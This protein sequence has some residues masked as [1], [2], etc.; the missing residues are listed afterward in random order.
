MWWQ[1]CSAVGPARHVSQ[2]QQQTVAHVVVIYV[3]TYIKE[4]L[5]E[6][7][8][9]VQWPRTVDFLRPPAGDQLIGGGC[10][11][12]SRVGGGGGQAGTGTCGLSSTAVAA[13][14]EEASRWQAE[15]ALG[16]GQRYYWWQWSCSFPV[17]RRPY[18]YL[19][20]LDA[21]CIT[22]FFGCSH[23]PPPFPVVGHCPVLRTVCLSCNALFKIGSVTKFS[24]PK[25]T[26]NKVNNWQSLWQQSLYFNKDFTQQ[27]LPVKVY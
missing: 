20:N 1:L 3:S 14:M 26:R 11:I 2:N 9:H 12:T 13:A 10:G 21:A 8:Q 27:S 17:A 5:L 22:H 16:G 23:P 4:V 7:V 24:L 18:S 25:F 19:V 15:N 6:Y